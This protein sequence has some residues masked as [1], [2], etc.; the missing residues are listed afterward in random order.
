MVLTSCGQ[1]PSALPRLPSQIAAVLLALGDGSPQATARA[2][3]TLRLSIGPETSAE[4]I[5]TA[6]TTIAQVVAR[7][8][9]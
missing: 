5:T 7:L 9:S 1:K 6:A 3:G 4:D 2:R 8:R